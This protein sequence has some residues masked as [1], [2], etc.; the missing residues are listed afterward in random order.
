MLQATHSRVFAA[1]LGLTAATA[2]P[3]QAIAQDT[4]KTHEEKEMQT[5]ASMDVLEITLSEPQFS[6]L[7]KAIKQAGLDDVLTE[8]GPYTLFAPT[9]D[10]FA[11][12]PQGEVE[13]LLDP[14]NKE[15]LVAL[16]KAHLVMGEWFSD[17]FTSTQ[18]LQG[19]AENRL[20]IEADKAVMVNDNTVVEADIEASNGVVHAINQVIKID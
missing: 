16:L 13:A 20:T 15:Q 11:K 5:A 4:M 14:S 10:A 19:V 17:D 9:N 3:L 6:T 2:L 12:L 1:L 7:Y 8:P 18:E